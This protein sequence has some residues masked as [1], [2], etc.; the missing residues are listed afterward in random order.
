VK[1]L[2]E[3]QGIIRKKVLPIK[4]ERKTIAGSY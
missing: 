4:K 1:D 2:T 3:N